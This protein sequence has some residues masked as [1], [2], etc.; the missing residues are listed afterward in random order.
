MTRNLKLG[1]LITVMVVLGSQPRVAFAEAPNPFGTGDAPPV[2]QAPEPFSEEDMDRANNI[3]VAPEPAPAFQE[4]PSAAPPVSMQPPSRRSSTP[5][6]TPPTPMGRAAS[7]PRGNLPPGLGGPSSAPAAPSK[8][9][10]AAAAR[11][12]DYLQ[13]DSSVKGLEVKNFDLPDK[14]IRDVVTLISKW[15]GKNFIIDSKVRGKITILGPS[16]V[17]LEEAYQAFLSALDANGLTTVKSGKFIRII[18]SAEARRAPVETYAGDYTPDTDQFITRIFQ[19]KYINADEVQRE[20]RDLTTR[21]GKLFAYEPT[22][23]I[24]ITDTGSNIKRIQEIINTIDV[25]GFETTLHVLRIKNS[26]SKSISEMLGDIYG[27][28][29]QGG[30]SSRP[31]TFRRSALERT[32]GGGIISKIIPDEQT[33]SLLVLANR[34]GFEQ[35]Q[36]LVKKLDVKVADTGRIHVYYCEYAKAED[37]AATLASLTGGS[38]G[39]AG[40]GKST[41]RKATTTGANVAGGG[42]ATPAAGRSGPV[43]AELEGGVK[44]SSDA[45]TNSLVVTANSGDYKTLKRVIKKLD[46]PRLQVLVETA[47]LEITVGKDSQYGSNIGTSAPGR[48][49]A[50]GFIG[51]PTSLS[52]LLTNGVPPGGLTIPIVSPPSFSVPLLNGTTT[53]NVTAFSF[54][55]MLRLLTS[56]NDSSVL[57]TPQII[58]M[59]N[60]KAEFK[61]QDETPVQSGFVASVSGSA[62]AIGQA[63]QGTIERLKTGIDIN[64]TPHINAASKSIRLEIEQKVDSIRDSGV[65]SSLSGIQKAT[66]SRVTNTTVVVKDQDF[67]VLGGLMSDKVDETTQKV[68]LLGDIPI[69]GWLFKAKTYKSVK[70]NLVILLHPRIIGT[71]SSAAAAVNDVLD[72]RGKFIDKTAGGDDPNEDYVKEVREK[73]E[74]QQA[75]SVNDPFE[76]YRNNPKDEEDEDKA[77]DVEDFQ[78]NQDSDAIKSDP[79]RGAPSRASKTKTLE[80]PPQDRAENTPP[81]PMMDAPAGSE[82]SPPPPDFG[83]GE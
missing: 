27:D 49:F 63:G 76:R 19:L 65:P 69:L 24:I 52:S 11:L 39:A 42:A 44:V 41:N 28:D 51:D 1:M 4:R 22:N 45:S 8:T 36:Q 26:S 43:S 21:Q 31:R 79:K 25:K 80:A 81:P 59:D 32:R 38:S 14:E 47:I 37:L 7:A 10:K 67:L 35:L 75:S 5:S 53:T 29:R 64:L 17:T 54:M 16:Q 77:K 56:N 46:I 40:M 74:K 55:G 30:G 3:P 68:P 57:S 13:L 33:N 83:G 34:A 20:F 82:I 61:V 66:T 71:S 9:S 72:K 15:T 78:D 62:G 6:P 70:S 23:S 58:A 12:A 73:L 50:G 18:E 2:N 48:L 60:E